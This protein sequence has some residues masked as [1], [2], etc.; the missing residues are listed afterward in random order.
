MT[1][2]MCMRRRRMLVLLGVIACATGLTT[3]AQA[4]PVPGECN[5]PASQRG[6]DIGCYLSATETLGALPEDARFWHIYNYPTRPAAEAV[7]APRGP[8]VDAFGKVWLYAIA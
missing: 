4:P 2:N 8:V 6:G 5:V 1:T 7:K 3:D